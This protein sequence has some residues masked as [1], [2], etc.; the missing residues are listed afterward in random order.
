[1]Q[2]NLVF[3]VQQEQLEEMLMPMFER[4]VHDPEN[5]IAR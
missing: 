4:V 3:G 1:V 2:R 5:R